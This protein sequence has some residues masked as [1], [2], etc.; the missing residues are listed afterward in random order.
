MDPLTL[1]LLGGLFGGGT[2]QNVTTTQTFA[3]AFNP[4]IVTNVGGG[5]NANPQGGSVTA[6]P[7]TTASTVDTQ[8]PSAGLFGSPTSGFTNT[9]AANTLPVSSSFLSPEIIIIG[10]LAAAAYLLLGGKKK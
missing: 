6:S 4:S 5:V 8:S 3:L 9:G 1:G 10:G 2:E 7:T